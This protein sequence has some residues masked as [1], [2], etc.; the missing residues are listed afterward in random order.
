MAERAS[1]FVNVAMWHGG[2]YSIATKGAKDVIDGATPLVVDA[3][4][5]IPD[6]DTANPFTLTDMGCADGGTSIDMVRQATAAVRARWPRRP[7]WVVYADQPRNDYNSLFH[8]IHGLTL[9]GAWRAPAGVMLEHAL[10]M[11][12]SLRIT[13][14]SATLAGLP[15][16][17]SRR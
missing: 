4:R 14:V 9:H 2:H 3:I 13:A 6:T 1:S 11:V 10:R 7:I 8:L 5:R 15:R 16:P 12:S 17:R